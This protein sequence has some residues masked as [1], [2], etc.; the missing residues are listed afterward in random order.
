MSLT[1]GSCS[2]IISGDKYA[3]F[4]GLNWWSMDDLAVKSKN[5]IYIL[6]TLLDNESSTH[7]F[8]YYLKQIC[9]IKSP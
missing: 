3:F 4:K 7:M 8:Q 6:S 2:K 1:D 5:E 9:P